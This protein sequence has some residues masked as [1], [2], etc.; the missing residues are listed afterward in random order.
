MRPRDFLLFMHHALQTAINRGHSRITEDDIMKAEEHYSRDLF[1]G[2]L[3]EL[4][5]IENAKGD[6]L[7]SFLEEKRIISRQELI[8]CLEDAKISPDAIENTID[9]LLWFSFLGVQTS[10]MSERYSYQVEYDVKI[11]KKLFEW[12][13]D[14]D[15]HYYIH[16][17]FSKVLELK[18]R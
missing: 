5:D 12:A 11:L 17:G 9:Q 2:L 4:N 10:D 8:K 16:P 15:K 3:Y 7:Y 13:K 18:N 14:E 1:E 6:I